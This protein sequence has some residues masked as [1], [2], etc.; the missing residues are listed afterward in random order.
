MSVFFAAPT[1]ASACAP[2]VFLHSAIAMPMY[3]QS[4]AVVSVL[5]RLY[6]VILECQQLQ[7]DG[8]THLVICKLLCK[9]YAVCWVAIACD[10]TEIKSAMNSGPSSSYAD[11]AALPTASVDVVLS[12]FDLRR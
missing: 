9:T 3:D 10:A 1:V 2:D 7:Y 5:F 11:A 6:S 12:P 4:D 8:L